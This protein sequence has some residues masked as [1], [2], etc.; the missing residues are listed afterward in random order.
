MNCGCC[1]PGR[2]LNSVPAPVSW[3]PSPAQLLLP[4][5]GFLTCHLFWSTCCLWYGACCTPHH[6]ICLLAA[7]LWGRTEILWQGASARRTRQGFSGLFQ[8]LVTCVLPKAGWWK[9]WVAVAK[10][11][12]QRAFLLI[13]EGQ[14]T[15]K[16]VLSFISFVN[17]PAIGEL[18]ISPTFKDKIAFGISNCKRKGRRACQYVG[19]SAVVLLPA[20]IWDLFST[21]ADSFPW[22]CW[23]EH[24]APCPHTSP[25]QLPMRDAQKMSVCLLPGHSWQLSWSGETYAAATSAGTGGGM[26]WC[27]FLGGWVE[28]LDFYLLQRGAAGGVPPPPPHTLQCLWILRGFLPNIAGWDFLCQLCL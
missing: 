11:L 16:V 23:G 25:L 7:R 21:L 12:S 3:E 19:I 6:G 27:C 15:D 26:L 2:L 24:P 14:Q 18:R 1:C 13:P 28:F 9:L 17:S 20:P 22:V 8:S 5:C 4:F 10:M